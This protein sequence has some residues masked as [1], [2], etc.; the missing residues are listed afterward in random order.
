MNNPLKAS[1]VETPQ[2][3]VG[4]VINILMGVIGSIALAMFTWGGFQWLIAMGDSKKV[5]TGKDIMKWTAFGMAMIFMAYAVT[6]ALI[7]VITTK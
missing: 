3:F 2:Q 7:E 6:R 5:Q 4:H 1:G